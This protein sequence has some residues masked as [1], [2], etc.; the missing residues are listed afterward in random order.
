MSR[1]LYT[2]F[3]YAVPMPDS[4][5]ASTDAVQA[6]VRQALD[7]IEALPERQAFEA[8]GKLSE[9]LAA[10]SSAV[11]KLRAARVVRHR[12]NE[13]LSLAGLADVLGISKARA[14]QLVDYA[15]S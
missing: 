12:A 6:A 1:G 10:E 14:Q 13:G 9:F 2:N 15:K 7:E 11:A 3:R 4:L 5:D 8:A